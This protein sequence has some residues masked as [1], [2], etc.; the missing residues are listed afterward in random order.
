VQHTELMADPVHHDKGTS[1]AGEGARAWRKFLDATIKNQA[2]DL[3][4][5]VDLPPRVRV[6]NV[7]RDLKTDICSAD[8]MF[9]IAK[10]IL[11]EGQYAHFRKRG[12]IDFA[13]DYDDSNRFR[14]NLFMARGKPSVAARLITSNIRRFEELYLP[15]S[16]GEVAPQRPGAHPLLRRHRFRQEHVD[17]RDCSSTSTS[18]SACTSSRSRIRSSTSSGTTRRRSTSAR[19]ASTA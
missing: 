2:S 14:V 5:K 4:I 9:Q 13:Y 10:E 15:P 8:L 7:L 17:C 3:I 12:S 11:D 6:R 18:A 16:L 1:V 19:W